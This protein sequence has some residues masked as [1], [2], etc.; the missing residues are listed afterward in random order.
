[1]QV[2]ENGVRSSVLEGAKDAAVERFFGGETVN[3]C[4]GEVLRI[5]NMQQN[6]IRHH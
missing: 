4:F 6:N 5:F 3:S 2:R 1:M